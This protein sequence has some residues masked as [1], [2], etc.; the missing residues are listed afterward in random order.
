MSENDSLKVFSDA[1][2]SSLPASPP[3]SSLKLTPPT[4]SQGRLIRGERSVENQYRIKGGQLGSARKAHV[5]AK[6]LI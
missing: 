6:G 3:N 5:Y 4:G 1:G 2:G